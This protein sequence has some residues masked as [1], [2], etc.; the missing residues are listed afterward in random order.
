M[1]QADQG[2]NIIPVQSKR[3]RPRKH[4]QPN[5]SGHNP[6]GIGINSPP[7][8]AP[9]GFEKRVLRTTDMRVGSVVCAFIDA[10]LDGGS[11]P[12]VLAEN[13]VGPGDPV[14]RRNEIIQMFMVHQLVFHQLL[15]HQ[16]D[17]WLKPEAE[18][19]R[20]NQPSI[21]AL[22]QAEARSMILPEMP[23]EELVT[24]LVK[25]IHDPFS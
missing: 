10:E 9:P 6:A 14:I 3:G 4:P 15:L 24:E 25:R 5:N 8:T 18:K 19:I 2:N 20:V 23:F 11:Y 17:Q 21:E 7:P 16:M 13:G 22:L 1:S 12:H